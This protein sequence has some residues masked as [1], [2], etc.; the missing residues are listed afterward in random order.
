VT[1]TKGTEEVP[2][3]A[4]SSSNPT[5]TLN[6]V[7]HQR[8]RLG[9]LTIAHEVRRAEFRY[10]LETLGLTA[11]NLSQHIRVLEEAGLIRVDK[12]IEGRKP[13][14][15]VSISSEGR[16]A[17]LEEIATLKAIVSRVEGAGPSTE[18]DPPTK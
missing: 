9:I 7:V 17:L 15:W 2:T 3:V 4:S 11:G 8:A 12:V 18:P 14:T 13:R 10:L 6:D 1:V 16:R 5:D